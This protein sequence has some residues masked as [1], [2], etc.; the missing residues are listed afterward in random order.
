MSEIR[1]IRRER[2][3]SVEELAKKVGVHPFSIYRYE[4]GKREPGVSVANRIAKAL[5]C[6]I[7]DLVKETA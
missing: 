7:E 1:R 6:T 2:G 4:S 3:M 5:H